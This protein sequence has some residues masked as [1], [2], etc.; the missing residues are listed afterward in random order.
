MDGILNINKPIGMSSFDVVKSIKSVT[1]VKKVGHAGTLDPGASGVLP[2]C[3]GCATKFVDYIMKD[4]KVYIARLKLGVE[5]DTYDRYGKI[6]SKSNV[7][8]SS[9]EIEDA[10]LS[11]IGNIQQIPPMYSALKVNGK[12][13]YELARKGIEVERKS[14]DIVIHNIEILKLES[15][16]VT[17]RIKCSKGTYIRSL[18]Y[19]IGRKLGCGGT[20]WSL[21]RTRTGKFDILESISVSQ[22]D[23]NNIF[24]YLIPI[25]NVLSGYPSIYIE[26]KFNKYI[27]NGVVI[28]DKKF[29]NKIDD[30]VLYKV[31]IDGDNFIGLGINK[32]DIGF[33]MIKLLIRGN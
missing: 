4:E 9:E 14:R 24:Y 31:Y 7:D 5:T 6:T 15:P 32:K 25:D 27:L 10:V 2:V 21:V 18:C 30:D 13:L 1:G 33:K 29:L 23:K 17:M 11:F 12:R 16:Y 19:D 20:M 28:K 22:L 3:I 26:N 8:V